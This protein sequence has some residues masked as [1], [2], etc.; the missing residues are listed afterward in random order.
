MDELGMSWL[1]PEPLLAALLEND[2]VF[3]VKSLL[4]VGAGIW[5]ELEK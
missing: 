1:L 5:I 3:E 2:D 4:L